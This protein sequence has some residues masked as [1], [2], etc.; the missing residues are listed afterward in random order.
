MKTTAIAIL[1]IA[2]SVAAQFSLKAGVRGRISDG[3]AQ[4]PSC[5]ELASRLNHN[6]YLLGG[7]MIY[8]LGAVG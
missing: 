1:S 2:C 3:S 4:L 5:S 8:G 7:F 6:H